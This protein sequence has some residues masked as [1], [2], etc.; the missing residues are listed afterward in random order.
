MTL[1]LRTGIL[2]WDDSNPIIINFVKL[3]LAGCRVELNLSD[4]TDYMKLWHCL[5]I[6]QYSALG[7]D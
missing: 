1:L 7:R 5:R 4:I 3:E 2:G 6:G